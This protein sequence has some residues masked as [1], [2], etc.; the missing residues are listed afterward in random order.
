M[1][2]SVIDVAGRRIAVL[3]NQVLD[4]GGYSVIWDG[5]G[6]DGSSVAS[7]LYFAVLEAGSHRSSR[8]MIR[9]NR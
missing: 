8:R 5:R 1:K 9:I 3:R 6:D 7:G 2:L 4:A